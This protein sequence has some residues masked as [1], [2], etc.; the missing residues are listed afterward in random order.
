VTGL[1]TTSGSQF[2][3]WS[4]TYRLFSQDRL[5]LPEIFS[6]VRR[7]IADQ[8]PAGAPFRAV[9]DDSLLRRAGLHTPGVAWRRDPLGPRFQTN[10]VRGQRFLQVSAAMPGTD[11]AYRLA[12][13]SFLHTPTPQKPN[14]KASASDLVQYRL[15]ARAS[16]ISLRAAQQMIQLRHSLDQDPGGQQRTLLLAFDGGYTNSTVLKQIPP[17]PTC[18]GRIRKDAR[19]CFTPLPAHMKT[20]GRRLCYG[21]P[22]PTPDQLRTDDSQPW[23][24]MIFTHS[25]I[26]HQLRYKRCQYIMWRTAGAQQILQ[27]VVI[28]PLAYRP[29]KGS[30]LLYRD[31]AYLICTDPDLEP[32]QII[33]AYFQRWDIE[34][35]F[36]DEKTLLGVGQA[37]VRAEPSVES[38]PALTVAAYALLLVSAQCAFGN[39][40]VGLLPQPK[41][42]A[43]SKGPRTSTQQM[44]HQLRA[45]VWGRGLGIDS[46]SDFASNLPADTKPGK[47]VF[48]LA[49]AACYANG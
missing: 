45:E 42:A 8:L 1:L 16:R 37:Q 26:A 23:Q 11:G 39:S 5:P 47:C 3:D 27:L 48:P 40:N 43:S 2:Q 30:K 44:L 4:A 13:I 9:L 24:T 41:W 35:N 6:V 46:F 21:L 28:A 14:R 25:G 10:F 38:A 34:V 12:P 19:L 36:R 32:R 31:P 22:A 20:R 29:R 18:I 33:E 17:H 7:A 15:D 49:S